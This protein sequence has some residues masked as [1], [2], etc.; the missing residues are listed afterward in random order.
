MV[1]GLPINS[2]IFHGELLNKQMVNDDNIHV[3]TSYK[4]KSSIDSGFFQPCLIG[5]RCPQGR[6][7]QV[8]TAG[9]GAMCFNSNMD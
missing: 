5:G 4:L 7:I 6:N 8:V 1:Y 3:Y 9:F 2:M